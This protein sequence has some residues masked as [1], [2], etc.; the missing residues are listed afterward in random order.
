MTTRKLSQLKTG[1]Y[2]I[3]DNTVYMLCSYRNN[4]DFIVLNLSTGEIDN[5]KTIFDREVTTVEIELKING[6]LK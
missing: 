6:E 1:Q 3:L 5:I 4:T 2:F